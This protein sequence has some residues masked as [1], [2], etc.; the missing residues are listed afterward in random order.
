MRTVW[1]ARGISMSSRCAHGMVSK[2]LAVKFSEKERAVYKAKADV[3]NAEAQKDLL[4]VERKANKV[5]EAA[6]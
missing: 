5:R 2:A 6:P 4:S 3:I 1:S